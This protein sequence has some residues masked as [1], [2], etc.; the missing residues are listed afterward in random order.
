MKNPKTKVHGPEETELIQLKKEMVTLDQNWKRALADYQNVV[1]RI[2]TEK[3][4]IIRLASLNVVNRLVPTLD[5]LEMAASHTHDAGITM[6][7]KQFNQVLAEEG[8]VEI[9]PQAGEKFDPTLHECIDTLTGGEANTVAEMVLKGY[10][11]NG[12][13]LRPAKVKVHKGGN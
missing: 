13:T 3:Q 4:E 12:F 11:I 1:K 6:A 8:L 9:T 2:E 10:K 7:V 5:V